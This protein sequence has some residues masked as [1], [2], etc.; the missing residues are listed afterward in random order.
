MLCHAAF[1]DYSIMTVQFLFLEASD[2]KQ[3]GL[4]QASAA[5]S[6]LNKITAMQGEKGGNTH[7][8]VVLCQCCIRRQQQ[9]LD[10]VVSVYGSKQQVT[11]N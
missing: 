5:A 2:N 10:N 4:L 11:I 3:E 9:H 8:S 6:F 7:Y 1:D